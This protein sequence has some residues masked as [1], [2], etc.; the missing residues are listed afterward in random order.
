MLS[1]QLVGI[2]LCIFAKEELIPHISDLQVDAAGCGLM[3]V[4]VTIWLVQFIFLV[5]TIWYASAVEVIY[6]CRETREALQYTLCCTIA[7]FVSSTLTY[8]HMPTTGQG[9][10]VFFLPWIVQSPFK[11]KTNKK[12]SCSLECVAVNHAQTEPRLLGNSAKDL[13]HCAAVRPSP[14]QLHDDKSVPARVRTWRVVLCTVTDVDWRNRSH[15]FWL[16][17]LNYRYANISISAS[18]QHNDTS[19][20][21]L[22]KKF[23]V[24]WSC[25]WPSKH[26]PP[27]RRGTVEGTGVRV[28]RSAGARPAQGADADREC[29]HQ[30]HGGRISVYSH[31]L[32]SY[33]WLIGSYKFRTHVQVRH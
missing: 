18:Y 25:Y 24:S 5:T 16:G 20:K 33:S 30:F 11:K 2:R 1:K 32:C 12:K 7:A 21:D 3:G 26:R 10:R 27:R 28:R 17:D 9:S 19:R 22:E 29:L 4:M 8:A 6:S 14:Q 23:L 15:V 31:L 13:V